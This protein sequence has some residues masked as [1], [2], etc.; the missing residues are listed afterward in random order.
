[1]TTRKRNGWLACTAAA[2]MGLLLAALVQADVEVDDEK[3]EPLPPPLPGELRPE[4]LTKGPVHE[5]FATP[6]DFNPKPGEIIPK[7]PPPLVQELPPEQKPEGDNVKWVPGYWAWEPERKD[8][9]WISGFWRQVPPGRE[10][11][12]GYWNKVGDQGYQWIS[13]HWAKAGEAEIRYLPEPPQS[14]ENGP[15]VPAPADDYVWVPGTWV[16]DDERYLWQPGFWSPWQAG[17][18]WQPSCYQ[19]T[20]CGYIFCDGFWDFSLRRRG[21]LF[22]PCAFDNSLLAGG[23]GWGWGGWFRPQ[24][25]VDSDLLLGCLWA[26]P[27]GYCFG[28]YWGGGFGPGFGW[29]GWGGG[30]GWGLS[31]AFNSCRGG[32]GFGLGGCRPWW[33]LGRNQCCPLFNYHNCFYRTHDPAWNGNLRRQ[34]ARQGVDPRQRPASTFRDQQNLLARRD[35]GSTGRGSG[36][37]SAL[38]RPVS[39]VARQV[40]RNAESPL[41]LRPV[42]A[43]QSRQLAR[44]TQEVKMVSAERARLEQSAARS[45]KTPLANR[46]PVSGRNPAASAGQGTRLPPGGTAKVEAPAAGFRKEALKLTRPQ[47]PIT[48]Q[49]S[50]RIGPSIN[51]GGTVVIRPGETAPTERSQGFRVSAAPP[52]SS[53]RIAPPSNLRQVDPIIGSRTNPGFRREGSS[54]LPPTISRDRLPSTSRGSFGPSGGERLVIPQTSRG[55]TPSRSIDRTPTPMP[56]TGGSFNPSRSSPPPSSGGFR[57]PSGGSSRGSFSPGRSGS[58]GGGFSP[59]RSG[60][61]GS[62]GG[63]GFGGGSRSG[64]SK[65]GGRG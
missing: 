64:G 17:W 32:L 35:A 3:P 9:I 44:V 12:A 36:F 54:S 39:Q 4:V 24:V 8:Y 59:G 51:R 27:G 11:V 10:W 61:S 41:K 13:G 25:C 28:N 14:L 26:R 49:T 20:P 55:G 34:F 43:D 50:P 42:S 58:G 63:G 57:P 29:G 18:V 40:N 60:G 21:L 7:A 37:N 5:A 53:A 46:S 48:A 16:Y 33:N 65:G 23:W 15:P 62:R 47:S 30:C 19:Y 31:V 52:S 22:A 45:G 56:R 1:M 6:T 38:A 2:A